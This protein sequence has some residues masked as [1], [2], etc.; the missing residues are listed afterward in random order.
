MVPLF[1]ACMRLGNNSMNSSHKL[2][3]NHGR[4]VKR[5]RLAMH[6]QQYLLASKSDTCGIKYRRRFVDKREKYLR[7]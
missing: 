2:I 6:R 7:L 1:H 3:K 4:F 5:G